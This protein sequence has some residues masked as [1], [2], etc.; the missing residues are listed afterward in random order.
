MEKLPVAKPLTFFQDSGLAHHYNP[1]SDITFSVRCGPWIGY[2][3]YRQAQG[4]CD[5]MGIAPGAG[6]FTLARGQNVLL[7]T[8]DQGYKLRSIVRTCLL[9]DGKGQYGDIGYPM[10]IPSKLDRGEE[11]QFARWDEKTGTG[12]VRLNL[13]PAYPDEMGMASYTRDFHIYADR[14]VCRDRVVL[15]TPRQLS[16]LFQGK[17]EMGIKLVDAQICRFGNGRRLISNREPV[18][19][20]VKASIQETP[21]VWSY[22]SGAG[23]KPFDHVRYDS[24]EPVRSAAVDFVFKW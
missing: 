21:V 11:I 4:P 3:A 24:A 12:W 8:P 5:R 20:E 2:H 18:G 14:L 9:V 19:F 23:F 22:S 15:N 17:R 13:A 7:A 16:W 1:K 6:H 10:S